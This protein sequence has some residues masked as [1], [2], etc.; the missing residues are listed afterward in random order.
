MPEFLYELSLYIPRVYNECRTRI[1]TEF[2][3]RGIGNIDHV[4]F[5]KCDSSQNCCSAFVHFKTWNN[6]IA[7]RNLQA[8]IISDSKEAKLYYDVGKYWL[9]LSNK[10]QLVKPKLIRSE[11]GMFLVNNSHHAV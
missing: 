1:Q 4:D 9:L 5:I 11:P 8:M 3:R 2:Q 6:T 7:T 10:S